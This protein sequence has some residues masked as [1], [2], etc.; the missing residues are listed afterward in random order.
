LTSWL[1][2]VSYDCNFAYLLKFCINI[3]G[4]NLALWLCS[5]RRPDAA[6]NITQRFSF[7]PMAV[8]AVA[9]ITDMLEAQNRR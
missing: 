6:L 3:E 8:V 2:R 1:P 5:A 7:T 4:G 9:P